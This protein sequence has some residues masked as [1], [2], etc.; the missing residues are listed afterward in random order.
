MA[1]EVNASDEEVVGTGRKLYTGRGQFEILAVNP[2][3]KELETLLGMEE[4]MEKEPSY[5]VTFKDKETGE[6][7]SKTSIRFYARSVEIPE[8]IV[9]VGF[10][11][12]PE[13]RISRT[14]KTQFINNKGVTVYADDVEALKSN[15]KMSWYD[16]DGIRPALDGE[17]DL[18]AFVKALANTKSDGN[19]YLDEPEATMSGDVSE[20]KG[21]LDATSGNKMQLMLGVKQQGDK[22]YQQVYTKW[23]GREYSKPKSLISA[24]NGEYSAFKALY[25]REDLSLK[26]FTGAIAQP[27]ASGPGP[28]AV[29]AGGSGWPSVQ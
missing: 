24:L 4:P 19:C 18:I 3:K 14:G 27:A 21:I 5:E 17:E 16:M 9:S 8:L 22:E 13:P 26:E 12:S 23:F 20:L 11:V 29:G 28:D 2:G 6:D 1:V 10:L 7:I 15:T 25:D